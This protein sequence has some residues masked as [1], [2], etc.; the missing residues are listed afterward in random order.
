MTAHKVGPRN[1]K[2][3]DNFTLPKYNHITRYE[4]YHSGPSKTSLIVVKDKSGKYVKFGPT[5]CTLGRIAGDNWTYRTACREPIKAA[6]ENNSRLI[7]LGKQKVYGVPKCVSSEVFYANDV[8]KMDK[9]DS[10]WW[11]NTSARIYHTF[12][13][14]GT[15][16]TIQIASCYLKFLKKIEK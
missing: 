14:F 16:E 4:R 2:I 15:H 10:T 9:V 6:L 3:G 5:L 1:I 8:T 13:S 11:F 12:Y 7:Y